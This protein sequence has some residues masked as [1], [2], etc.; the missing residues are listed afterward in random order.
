MND[1]QQWVNPFWQA[2]TMAPHARVLGVR[3]SPL[4]VWHVFALE[5]LECAFIVGGEATLGDVVQLLFV[6]SQTRNEFLTCFHDAK[7]RDRKLTLVRRTMLR[8][9]GKYE[10][11]PN[12]L[13][14]C[15]VY[16]SESMR[17]PGRW[18][19]KGAKPCAVPHAL[20]VFAAAVRG[21]VAYQSAW[22]MPYMTARCLFDI[23]AEQRGDES[24][25]TAAAMQMD[26]RMAAELKE[27]VNG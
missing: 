1:E 5:Q 22:D 2:F 11:S 12:A 15:R 8:N 14:V 16:V 27:A 19:K 25:Q 3:V 7:K 10:D 18:I 4:S 9:A 6:V 23:Q 26:E 13:E 21:G 17:V 20:H 24:L